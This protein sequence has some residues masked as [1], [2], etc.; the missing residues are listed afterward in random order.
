MTDLIERVGTFAD[1]VLFPAAL[2][3]DRHGD[4]PGSHWEAMASLGLYGLAAPVDA[5]GPG[6][7]LD[8][9]IEILETMAAGCLATTFTWVQHHGVV[10]GLANTDN[11]ALRDRYLADV[12]AGR[13]KGGVAFAGVI[14]DPP[15]MHARRVGGGWALSG[16][17]PFVSG[18]GIVDILQVSAG[19]VETGDVLSGIVAATPQPG[20]ERI[21]LHDLVAANGTRTVSL[22]VDGL[23]LP[24]EAIVARVPRADFLAN[25]GVAVRFNGTL[26]LGLVRRCVRLLLEAGASE[27]AGRF[28]AELDTVRA[29]MDAGL[30]DLA[31]LNQARAD[32]AQL[33]VRASAA[34][35]A[36]GG[37]PSLRR[38][39]HAQRLA[40]EAVFVLVAASRA[41]VKRAL[42]AGFSGA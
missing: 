29:R 3:V 37:G 23:L 39:R 42:L 30:V 41:E 28:A 1:E 4:I 36:A 26:S 25:Q 38:D 34:L 35:V 5:G 10:A 22:L 32:G 17:A 15:R 8:G 2:D 13:I 18:W 12:A 6:L 21:E 31:V 7:G 16:E 24:D 19:D 20:I 9:I 33:A 11:A 40:R 27:A 14:P